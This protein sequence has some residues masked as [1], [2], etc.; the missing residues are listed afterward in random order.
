LFD[1][2]AGSVLHPFGVTFERRGTDWHMHAAGVLESSGVFRAMGLHVVRTQP[3]PSTLVIRDGRIIAVVQPEL[4]PAC[5]RTMVAGFATLTAWL[6]TS[7]DPAGDLL[8]VDGRLDLRAA[9]VAEIIAA[10]T[11]W[12]ARTGWQP[13]PA[14]V[15]QCAGSDF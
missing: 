7:A 4:L 12:R 11:A 6:Q 1:A 2:M 3:V 13:A 9:T 15:A 5:T 10:I 14:D 8:L